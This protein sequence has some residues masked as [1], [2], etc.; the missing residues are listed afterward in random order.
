MNNYNQK[1]V[2]ILTIL[3]II[4]LVAN[5]ASLS[6]I[7]VNSSSQPEKDRMRVERTRINKRE[8][9]MIRHLDM[10]TTQVE[11]Y[12]TA[13]RELR[14]NLRQY[15]CTMENNRKRIHEQLFS[16]NPD[17]NLINT[18][19]D[20]IGL[21]TIEMEKIKI[22]HFLRMKKTLTSEQIQKFRQMFED[23]DHERMRHENERHEEEHSRFEEHRK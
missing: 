4:L 3:V 17:T 19:N 1:T 22:N 20:S 13:Q 16:D 21:M 23:D 8:M 2:R 6:V 7:W 11:T 9:M 14:K 15:R 5:I 12:K 10:D 18:L